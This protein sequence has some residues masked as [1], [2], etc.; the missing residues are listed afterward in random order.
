MHEDLPPE[1]F[2][3]ITIYECNGQFIVFVRN[4][5]QNAVGQHLHLKERTRDEDKINQ[6]KKWPWKFINWFQ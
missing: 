3:P 6:F 5:L 1:Y 2:Q 4:A